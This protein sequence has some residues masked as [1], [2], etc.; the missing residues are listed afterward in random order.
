A[1]RA[2]IN[3]GLLTPRAETNE[4]WP[5]EG[6]LLAPRLGGPGP[7][8]ADR[9]REA[10]TFSGPACLTAESQPKMPLYEL[11]QSHNHL[12]EY[13]LSR[14]VWYRFQRNLGLRGQFRRRFE[15]Y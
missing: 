14:H 5:S 11:C 8:D 6:G 2:F 10:V 15:P 3:L 4:A 12:G 13:P 9:S 1:G 7:G